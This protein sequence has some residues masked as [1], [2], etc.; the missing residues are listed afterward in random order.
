MSHTLDALRAWL[1]GEGEIG[2]LRD[3]WAPPYTGEGR[4]FE[5]AVTR[6]INFAGAGVSEANELSEDEARAL[7][8]DITVSLCMEQK[9]HDARADARVNT[10]VSREDVNNTLIAFETDIFNI[11]RA[12]ITWRD[13]AK[14]IH[15][16]EE[17]RE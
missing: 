15:E 6:L 14:A 11:I 13:I 8:A 16:K 2:A 12:S 3:S 1:K 5:H 17:A 7:Y 9:A 10:W 4:L